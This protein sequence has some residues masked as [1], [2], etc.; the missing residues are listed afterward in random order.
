MI[1]MAAKKAAK[2]QENKETVG[3]LNLALDKDE[4]TS[5]ERARI[6]GSRALQIAQGAKPLVKITKKEIEEIGYNPITIAKREFVAGKVPLSV[7]R[8]LPHEDNEPN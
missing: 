7:K 8:S 3:T 5:Y 2:T 4:Y 6:I 1:L